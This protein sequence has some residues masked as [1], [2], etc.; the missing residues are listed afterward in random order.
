MKKFI[1][2]FTYRKLKKI[3]LILYGF[4]FFVVS[5][6]PEK[7]NIF[8]G[9]KIKNGNNIVLVSLKKMSD[10][11]Y[12]LIAES[13]LN[14][15]KIYTSTIQLKYPIYHF[16]VGDVNNDGQDDIAV[17]VIK[18]TY[19]D[20]VVRKRPFFFTLENGTI[21]KLWTGTSLTYP[22]ED[23]HIVKEDSVHYLRAIELERDHKYLVAQ[24]IWNGFGFRIH[25]YLSREISL[26]EA[27]KQLNN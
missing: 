23:F 7:P 4:L 25:Q 19:Y 20:K 16:E 8:D 13:Y 14:Q 2:H 3:F 10:S 17:G 18:S 1:R 12:F 22:L 21:I 24:Y 6:K 27:Y 11:C 5:C 26:K 15:K 9:F